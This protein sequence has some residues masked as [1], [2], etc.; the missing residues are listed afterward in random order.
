MLLVLTILNFSDFCTMEVTYSDR[1]GERTI[2]ITK[3]NYIEGP[4]YG[5]MKDATKLKRL[6]SRKTGDPRK[7]KSRFTKIDDENIQTNH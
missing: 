7:C 1:E 3:E 4:K 5:R 2:K 6:K